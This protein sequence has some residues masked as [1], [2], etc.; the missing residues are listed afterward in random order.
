MCVER[1]KV[2]LKKLF[3]LMPQRKANSPAGYME[4]IEVNYPFE[5]VGIDLLTLPLSYYQ[6]PTNFC[7]CGLFN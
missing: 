6:R 4:C 1:E 3:P 7:S 5:K 2:I